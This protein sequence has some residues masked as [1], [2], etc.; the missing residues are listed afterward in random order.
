STPAGPGRAP[1]SP[2]RPDLGRAAIER[3]LTDAVLESCELLEQRA[4]QLATGILD[5]HLDHRPHV[6]LADLD[7]PL[8]LSGQG[9]PLASLLVAGTGGL[10]ETSPGEL[11]QRARRA[12]LRHA[13]GLGE[14][15]DRERTEPIDRGQKGELRRLDR[16]LVRVQD[17]LGLRLHAL[18]EALEPRP[19]RQVAKLAND[20]LYHDGLY[21]M[22]CNASKHRRSAPPQVRATDVPRCPCG[23][24]R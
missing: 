6:A 21:N 5:R 17:A 1:S 20:V 14:L 7:E 10:D 9:H 15:A 22:L 16:Q 12:G 8:A 13:D 11:P 24:G 18:P 2:P 19:E 3:L 4:R 23:N